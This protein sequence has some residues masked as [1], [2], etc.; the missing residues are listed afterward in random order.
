MGAA[1][2]VNRVRSSPALP[3][4]Q[5]GNEYSPAQGAPEHDQDNM[6]VS[7]LSM[8]S[9]TQ[10]L[11]GG[12][13]SKLSAVKKKQQAKK[14]GKGGSVTKYRPVYNDD[15]D[16]QSKPPNLDLLTKFAAERER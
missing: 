13:K 5:G 2:E 9:K 7:V 8:D 12:S 3:L 11:Q 6:S 16:D 1:N 4:S 14:G 10:Q 15:D